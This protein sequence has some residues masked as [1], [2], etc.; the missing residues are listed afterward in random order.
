MIRI[1]KG[2]DIEKKYKLHPDRS[3]AGAGFTLWRRSKDKSEDV[4]ICTGDGGEI[5][6]CSDYDVVFDLIKNGDA[7]KIDNPNDGFKVTILAGGGPTKKSLELFNGESDAMKK[8]RSEVSLG[9]AAEVENRQGDVIYANGFRDEP[10]H[11]PDALAGELYEATDTR[12]FDL[13]GGEGWEKDRPEYEDDE[14]GV[15]GTDYEAIRAG[16][17]LVRQADPDAYGYGAYAIVLKAKKGDGWVGFE[18]AKDLESC[19]WIKR[20]TRANEA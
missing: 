8:A 13:D 20:K 5:R 7:E 16:D 12:Y 18:N 14:E 1:K 15:E 6:S 9:N 11:G 19:D 4:V 17:E 2:V 3:L 10:D